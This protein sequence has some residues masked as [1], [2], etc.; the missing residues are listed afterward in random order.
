VNRY[1]TAPRRA[2]GC[3]FD[4]TLDDA[5]LGGYLDE[6]FAAL[7]RADRADTTI[8]VDGERGDY[9]L[10]IGDDTVLDDSEPFTVVNR[11]VQRLN[12]LATAS[13]GFV[14]AH[15]SGVERNG[16]AYVFPAHMESGKTTLAAGLVRAGFDY[17]TDEAVA[18]DPVTSLIEPYPKPLSL[19]PGSWSLFPEAEPDP[20]LRHGAALDQWQVPVAAL[21]AGA[22]GGPCPARFVVFPVYR[23]GATTE[24]V[25]M[26]RG[27]A[28]VELARNTFAFNEQGRFALDALARV[29]RVAE[30]GRLT[31]GSLDDAVARIEDLG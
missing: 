9:R 27:E 25:A 16:A 11:L 7:P 28:L 23:A 5:W 3:C 26:T 14:C 15:A 24:F 18:F 20:A 30:C 10:A 19:D 1:A 2:I 8:T 22:I 13:P 6:L 31:V 29:V 21:R 17:L 4:V 12:T